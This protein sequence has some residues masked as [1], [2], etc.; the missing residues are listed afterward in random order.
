MDLI[1][2]ETGNDDVRVDVDFGDVL[3][4]LQGAP[5]RRVDDQGDHATIQLA[6][7]SGY[8]ERGTGDQGDGGRLELT[9]LCSAIE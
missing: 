5:Q 6:G 3:Y 2:D 4:R 1:F 8:L 9:L 7:S